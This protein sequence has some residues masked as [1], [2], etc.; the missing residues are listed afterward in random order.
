M[1]KLIELWGLVFGFVEKRRL[2]IFAD[3]LLFGSQAR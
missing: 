3:W 2:G 1:K